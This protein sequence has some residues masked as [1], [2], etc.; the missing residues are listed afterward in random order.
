MSAD[1]NVNWARAAIVLSK[2]AASTSTSH[3][4]GVSKEA[5]A[6]A[7]TQTGD[8]ET[9]TEMEMEA[10]DQTATQIGNETEN[11]NEAGR[12]LAALPC[13]SLALPYRTFMHNF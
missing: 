9:G 1:I 6:E 3:R 2:E 8:S 12:S 4:R 13:Q 5:G 7:G 10:L 11:E